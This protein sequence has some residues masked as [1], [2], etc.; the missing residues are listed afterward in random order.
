MRNTEWQR[1]ARRLIVPQIQPHVHQLVTAHKWWIV[2]GDVGLVTHAVGT[3]ISK[4]GPRHVSNYAAVLS[5]FDTQ[6]GQSDFRRHLGEKMP[7]H[8]GWVELPEDPEGQEADVQVLTDRIVQEGLPFLRRYPDLDAVAARLRWLLRNDTLP[9]DQPRLA[10]LSALEILRG[11]LLAARAAA[12]DLTRRVE[13]MTGSS[14]KYGKHSFERAAYIQ[15]L[16][17]RA[18]RD[19]AEPQA[20]LWEMVTRQAKALGLPPPQPRSSR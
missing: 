6:P 12:E 16:N 3:E 9:Y 20:S 14:R 15:Q 7:G 19:L 18:E 4:S 8:Q 10:H 17:E 1:L 5:L 13:R 11:D 2:I